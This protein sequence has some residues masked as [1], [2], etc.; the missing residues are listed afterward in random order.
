MPSPSCVIVHLAAAV[1]VSGCAA[2]GPDF[3]RPE[4]AAPAQ[5]QDWH[6][7]DASLAG[8]LAWCAWYAVHALGAR[9]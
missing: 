6:G 5:W 7:G 3:Q 4:T 9:P 2:V 8:L 1:L